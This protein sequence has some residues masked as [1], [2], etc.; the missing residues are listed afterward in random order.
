MATQNERRT[1]T[2]ASIVDAARFFFGTAGFEATKID[3]I[4]AKAGVAKGA[5]YHHFKNKNEVFAAV[6]ERV[7]EALVADMLSELHPGKST[8]G[9][10]MKFVK[11]FFDLCA[12]P[13]TSRIFLQDGPA[14]LGY[15]EWRRLDTRH[16]GGLVTSALGEA[17][18]AGA[19]KKQ[20]LESLSRIMLG[21]IQAAAIDCTVQDDFDRAAKSYLIVFKEILD[22]LK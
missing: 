21:G 4:A 11:H 12:E 16:F 20:P 10:L 17:M 5:V 9:R 15:D 13:Q 8:A 18:K 22:G 14:V 1:T 19:I 7:S 3:D 2:R 6:F